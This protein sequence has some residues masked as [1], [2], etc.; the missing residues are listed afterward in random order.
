MDAIHKNRNSNNSRKKDKIKVMKS[1]FYE[2]PSVLRT[3][4]LVGDRNIKMI[5]TPLRNR[6]PQHQ[7]T[8]SFSNKDTEM[9][10]KGYK[11]WRR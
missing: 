2:S 4:N 3:K 1:S 9:D 8:N 6:I 10:L 7:S 11:E 5:R